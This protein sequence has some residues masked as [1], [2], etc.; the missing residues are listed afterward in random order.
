MS[1]L[2]RAPKT[3]P[4]P[5]LGVAIRGVVASDFYRRVRDVLFGP[6]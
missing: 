3:V 2:E 4:E 1:I 6:G 5:A